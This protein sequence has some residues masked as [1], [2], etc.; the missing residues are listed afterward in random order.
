MVRTSL[1]D[2]A[3]IASLLSTAECVITEAPKDSDS[4]PGMG[5][6]M[7]G[8]GGMP[9]GMDLNAMMANMGNFNGGEGLGGEDGEDGDGKEE[10]DSDDEG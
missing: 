9:G 1:V 3:G 6:G 7:G 10:V 4:N 2:A 8:M 5:G